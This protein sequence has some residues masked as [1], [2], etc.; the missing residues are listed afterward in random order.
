MSRS[1]LAEPLAAA[2]DLLPQVRAVRDELEE[3]RHMPSALARAIGDAGLFQLYLPSAIGGAGTPP[4]T[5]FR[6]IEELSK[7]EGSVGWCVMIANSV[8]LFTGWLA[9]EVAREM[10]GQP[11]VVRMAGSVRPEGKAW[12]VDG[13]YRVTGQW[14]FASGVHHANWLFCTCAV[15]D[16]DTPRRTASWSAGHSLDV[17]PGGKGDDQG[18]VVGCR[19]VRDRKPR[20]CHRRCFRAG[21]AHLFPCRTAEGRRAPV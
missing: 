16:G 4:L 1:T 20:F 3:L 11:P 18:Y 13:G 6:V 19:H 12:E 10:F 14:N 2:L 5:T 7:A 8:T 15:M 21:G 9:P 17:Y